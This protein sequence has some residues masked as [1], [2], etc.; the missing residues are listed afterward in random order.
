MLDIL[1]R[2]FDSSG[3]IVYE[4]RFPRSSEADFQSLVCSVRRHVAGV[5][6]VVADVAYPVR[7]IGGG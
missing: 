7:I 6:R 4:K 5:V 1:I 3:K 2:G